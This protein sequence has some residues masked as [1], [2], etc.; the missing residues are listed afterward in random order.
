MIPT[1]ELD[2]I[3]VGGGAYRHY[4]K[5]VDVRVESSHRKELLTFPSY[6]SDEEI[7]S[8]VKQRIDIGAIR[9]DLLDLLGEIVPLDIGVTIYIGDFKETILFGDTLDP[10]EIVNF[11]H[12]EWC[13]YIQRGKQ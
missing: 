11:R 7:K 6:S 10:Q 3:M 4:K 9:R 1:K 12:F 2:Y 5:D 8:A 13:Y